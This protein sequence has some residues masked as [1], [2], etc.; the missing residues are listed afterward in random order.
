MGAGQADTESPVID[1]SSTLRFDSPG[2][3]RNLVVV[4]Y[5]GQASGNPSQRTARVF[6]RFLIRSCPRTKTMTTGITVLVVDDEEADRDLA[7]RILKANGYT[8]VKAESYSDAMAAFDLHRQSIQLVLADV[9]LPDGNGCAMAVVMK[10]LKP[11]LRVLFA[12]HH[13]GSE[14]LKYYGLDVTDVHFHRKPF[15][16]QGLLRAIQRVLAN[17]SFPSLKVPR[18]HA[19]SE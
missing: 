13:V 5:W 12:S 14:A 10:Q 9:V 19:S 8:V 6:T 16:E 18:T 11:D 7:A 4:R 17:D 15:E 1:M 3:L 2:A